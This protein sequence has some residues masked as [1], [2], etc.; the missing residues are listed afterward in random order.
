M[1]AVA[2]W[3]LG[4]SS[5]LRNLKPGGDTR[6]SPGTVASASRSGG[7][8]L[9]F[10]AMSLL[11]LA[12]LG[13]AGGGMLYYDPDFINRWN[14][15]APP[16]KVTENQQPP[17][18]P[19]QKDS[20]PEQK[21]LPGTTPPPPPPPP[22]PVTSADKIRRYIE[23]YNGGDCFYATPGVVR[24]PFVEIEGFGA[25]TRAFE[26]LN[27]AFKRDNGI[28]ADVHVRVITQAQCPAI[29]FLGKLKG[30]R[31]RAPRIELDNFNLRNGEVLSGLRFRFRQPHRRVA[32]RF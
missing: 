19:N 32:A 16:A 23:Q 17:V 21:R 3:Q 1:A 15:F 27:D 14:P 4:S 9:R 11:L 31:A 2:N 20:Q 6:R 29:T 10:A 7:R 30:D 18:P 28:E 24:P 22:P 8:G 12:L 13:G 26:M 25:T 5:L